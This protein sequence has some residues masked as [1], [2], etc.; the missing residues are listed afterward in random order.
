M[1]CREYAIQIKEPY[2]IWGGLT[3]TER[4]HAVLRSA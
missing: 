1:E 2:G 3:E 4:R